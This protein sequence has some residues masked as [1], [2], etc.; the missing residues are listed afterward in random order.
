LLSLLL[1]KKSEMLRL[2]PSAIVLT[3]DEID[4]V[5]QKPYLPANEAEQSTQPASYGYAP[6]DHVITVRRQRS[7]R[8][9]K[10]R[11]S[12]IQDDELLSN[13]QSLTIHQDKD[14]GYNGGTEEENMDDAGSRSGTPASIVSGNPLQQH[15][16]STMEP[17][18]QD[19]ISSNPGTIRRTPSNIDGTF[20][21]NVDDF[22]IQ[23]FMNGY[24]DQD[25]LDS[26]EAEDIEYLA[27]IEQEFSG[28]SDDYDDVA[29][30]NNGDTGQAPSHLPLRQLVARHLDGATEIEP[31]HDSESGTVD[32]DLHHPMNGGQQNSSDLALP[33]PNSIRIQRRTSR[34]ID[35][36]AS[37]FAIY[38]E[39]AAQE[40]A[41]A[42][43]YWND[44][45]GDLSHSLMYS[46]RL[47]QEDTW[48]SFRRRQIV[49]G[50]WAIG[51][52]AFSEDL[53]DDSLS[54]MQPPADTT[55]LLEERKRRRQTEAARR[56]IR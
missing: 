20:S 8:K 13:F 17:P 12:I 44:M 54:G 27:D 51:N 53:S 45:S 5:L 21:L 36:L 47:A 43:G 18:E 16:D 23:N 25:F 2:R 32:V 39:P 29:R 7:R 31:L 6:W 14:H 41:Q 38:T 42:P 33:L 26:D 9:G 35:G 3:H 37:H 28:G 49:T 22:D 40:I 30:N 55:A 19:V 56:I 24:E 10:Q 52:S 34:T 48:E 50:E 1:P 11:A 4:R 46:P 15:M